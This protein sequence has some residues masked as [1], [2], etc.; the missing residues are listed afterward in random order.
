MF[1]PPVYV[2]ACVCVVNWFEL[3]LQYGSHQNLSTMPGVNAYPNRNMSIPQGM[4]NYGSTPH[5]SQ[6]SNFQGGM[7]GFR[8]QDYPGNPNVDDQGRYMQQYSMDRSPYQLTRTNSH[9]NGTG[10]AYGDAY[11]R[12]DNGGH[13][14]TTA[15]PYQLHK[16]FLSRENLQQG[17]SNMTNESYTAAPTQNQFYLHDPNAASP[18]VAPQRRTWAQTST[19][20]PV[21]QKADTSWSSGPASGTPRQSNSQG[22]FV[23]HPN[24][25]NSDSFHIDGAN[26]FPVQTS[27]PQHSRVHRQ[28]SQIIDESTKKAEHQSPGRVSRV[29][30][31]LRVQ[32]N[33][34]I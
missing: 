11:G 32:T 30:E 24:G 20:S 7:G 19:Q 6:Q 34:V 14:Q 3:H 27:S 13:Q 33:F 10:N 25:G 15:A 16:N 28:I 29:Y 17:Y 26:L 5:L 12:N 4:M 9:N 23:L 21:L 18:P 2:R 8:L 31:L 22:G 1:H